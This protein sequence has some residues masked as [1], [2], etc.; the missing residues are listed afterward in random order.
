MY[1]SH[2]LAEGVVWLSEGSRF[3]IRAGCSGTLMLTC[4]SM[5]CAMPCSVRS[6]TAI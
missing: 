1:D 5:R 3:R 6:L 4:W 2:R